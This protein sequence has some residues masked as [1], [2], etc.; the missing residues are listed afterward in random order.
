MSVDNRS[1][2]RL[3]YRRKNLPKDAQKQIKS[4]LLI[5]IGKR[6]AKLVQERDGGR[7][8]VIQDT[9]NQKEHLVKPFTTDPRFKNRVPA[10]LHDRLAI[11]TSV[12]VADSVIK[13]QADK[14]PWMTEHQQS[15]LL[16]LKFKN[17][18]H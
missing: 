6:I 13:G 15:Q 10:N 11:K 7:E 8:F 9:F 5:I 16:E 14:N 18:Q 2:K 12:K 4:I 17:G 1:Q 3:R